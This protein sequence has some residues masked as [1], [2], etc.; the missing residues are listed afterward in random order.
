MPAM[1]KARHR[2]TRGMREPSRCGDQFAKVRALVALKG[3]G[4]HRDLRPLARR[5]RRGFG[6]GGRRGCRDRRTLGDRRN[7]LVW[8]IRGIRRARRHSVHCR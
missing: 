7:R 6:R 8:S 4:H 1:T 3:V 5:H 2:R